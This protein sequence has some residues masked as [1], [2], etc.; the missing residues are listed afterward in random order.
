MLN[1]FQLLAN[2]HFPA[3]SKP[4][5]GQYLTISETTQIKNHDT[6]HHFPT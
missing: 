6:V 4:N 2:I 5:T 1:N 3:L